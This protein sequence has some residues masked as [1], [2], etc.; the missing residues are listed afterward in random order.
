MIV[1]M[2]G[3]G[4]AGAEGPDLRASVSVR[5]L[6]HRFLELSL[7]VSRSLQ[8]LEA[9]IKEIVQ[10][11]VRRG[12][13][14][15]SVQASLP[16][17]ATTAVV[18]S[19]PLV[20]GL[21]ATLRH[22]Q[23]EHGLEG[24]VTVSDVARFPGALEAV[25]TGVVLDEPQRKHVLGLVQEALDALVAMR[26]AEGGRLQPDLERALDAI[27]ESA[28]RIEALSAASREAR[29]QQLLERLRELVSELGL[30][31]PR[32]YQEVVRAVERHDVSEELQ[33]LRSHVSLAR[34]LLRGPQPSGKRLDFV[35]QELMREANTVGSKVADA[36]LAREVVALKA[37][38][39][40]LREQ[41]QNVE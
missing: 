32:L 11:R 7:R 41:V 17:A 21:V 31:E 18:A 27:Q 39:E 30:D 22:I 34:E 12:R 15:L 3:Y 26:R 8:A 28:G 29:R 25:E 33:R 23:T 2:T 14:D 20:A 19:R 37:E 40:K 9:E 13:V 1:S 16:E 6:N 5:S 4:A 36:E 24:G 38:V 10:S 35:A